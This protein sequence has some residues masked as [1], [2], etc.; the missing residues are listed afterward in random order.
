MRVVFF[1]TPDYAVPT[2]RALHDAGH[3]VVLVVAQP[4]KPAGRGKKLHKPPVGRA[5]IE[6][7]LPLSQPR[8][9]FTGRFPARYQ[10]LDADVAVVIAYG[11]I[12][13][14]VH[15]E[16]PRYGAVNLHA[17]LLPRWRGAAPIQ[18]A[19]LAGDTETGVAAQRME[20]GLDTGD[21]YLER[22]IPIG[23]HETAGEL[24][25]RLAALSA[26]IAVETLAML[27]DDPT[28]TPQSE[29]GVCWAPKISKDDGKL[30][31]TQ[32]ATT[33]DRQIRAMSP[34]PGGWIPGASG[35]LKVRSATPVEGSGD[36][37][38]VL[39]TQPLVVATGEGALQLDAVQ[40]PGKRLVSG[41]DFA[42][43]RRMSVGDPLWE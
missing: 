18:A 16:T 2:L 11:R 4:D 34:W 32:S 6:L 15:L 10:S 39:S 31:L 1:G 12:L 5:A 30:D 20:L 25:D 13:K 23:P 24:H 38:S 33:L 43:G 40:S 41:V 9:I 17:S 22:Q 8:A 37:G 42:N 3:D 19:I 36:P 21:V 7:G 26:E 28:P 35:A 14:T 29:T 27:P